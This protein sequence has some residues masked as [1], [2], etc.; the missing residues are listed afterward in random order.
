SLVVVYAAGSCKPR[1]RHFSA[2]QS[3]SSHR[4]A[5]LKVV[6]SLVFSSGDR[7]PPPYKLVQSPLRVPR[8]KKRTPRSPGSRRSVSVTISTYLMPEGNSAF[9]QVVGRHL[10]H[11]F[12]SWQD[13]NE[14]QPH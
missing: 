9:R 4:A 2:S 8:T 13:P 5:S 10:Y 12:V 7:G 14:M 1:G 3:Y 6:L 11:N